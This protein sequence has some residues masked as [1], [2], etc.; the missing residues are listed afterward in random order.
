M[1]GKAKSKSRAKSKHEELGPDSDSTDGTTEETPPVTLKLIGQ[2]V[3]GKI[4]HLATKECIDS[5][6]QTVVA[7]NEKIQELEAKIVLMEKYI[8]RTEKLERGYEEIN[9]LKDCV[10]NLELRCDDNE[11][12]HRRLCLRFNGIEMDKDKDESGE[13]CLRKIKTSLK[14]ELEVDI[15]DMVIDRAHRIGPVKQNPTTNK[16]LQTIIVRFTTWRHRSMVYRARKKS[17][18]FKVH[19]DLTHRKVKL[20][21]KANTWL[22]DK[23]ECFAFADINCRPC[24]FMDGDY[25]YFN[26]EHELLDLIKYA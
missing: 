26:D 23:N 22:K 14:D 24:L 21:E 8:E 1:S 17:E 3:E 18:K 15:P 13:S 12:Y 16:K 4:A 5:L 20:L 19:L 6:R 10:E 9:E 2:V 11:Q 7:Q 25:E